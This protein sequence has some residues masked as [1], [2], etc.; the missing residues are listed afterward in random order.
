MA[1]DTAAESQDR[2]GAEALT[3]CLLLM[4]G[5]D[6]TL[7]LSEVETVAELYA[8]ASGRAV[9]PQLISDIFMG[10]RNCDADQTLA[11]L[12]RVA[13]QL[14]DDT[15]EK[16]IK[17]SY[18]VMIADRKIDRRETERLTEIAEALEFPA[19]KVSALT[20]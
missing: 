7:T 9:D 3:R 6:K 10:T 1:Q 20:R 4:A 18:S 17:A 19:D 13:G 12:R 5:A 8:A 11:D 14:D 16:I 2:A 15:K